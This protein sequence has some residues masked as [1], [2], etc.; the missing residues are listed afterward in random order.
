MSSGTQRPRPFR[1][2][3]AKPRGTYITPGP[4]NSPN[5]YLFGL[6]RC[7]FLHREPKDAV[8]IG[9]FN[10]IGVNRL[11]Q[12]YGSRELASCA[13]LPQQLTAG[14]SLV[15]ALGRYD[16]GVL[17]QIDTDIFLVYARQIGRQLV[18]AFGFFDVE[19]KALGRGRGAA[20]LEGLR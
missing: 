6:G 10:G 8:Q 4:C 2:D 13:F 11:W 15:L 5:S 18:G 12:L 16:Q 20:W 14:L 17:V 1:S 9:R 19:R 7:Q 3:S